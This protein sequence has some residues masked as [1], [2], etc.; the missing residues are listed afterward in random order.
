MSTPHSSLV[1][2]AYLRCEQITK[3]AG[4]NFHWGFRFLP[5]PERQALYALYS[6]A[7]ITDDIVDDEG[8]DRASALKEWESKTRSALAGKPVSDPV[9]LALS[10]AAATFNMPHDEIFLLIEGCRDD[11]TIRRYETFDETLGYCRK[12]AVTVGMLMLAIFRAESDPAAR[13]GMTAI[14]HAFQLTNILR[15]VPEDLRRDRIYLPLAVM[16]D[17]GISE[18]ALAAGEGTREFMAEMV[19]RTETRYREAEILYRRLS[20]A[21][22][23]TMKAMGRIYEAIL[24]EIKSQNYD[25]WSRRPKVSLVKKIRIIISTSLG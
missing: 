18:E 10:H 11:L 3:A 21:P 8:P 6:F 9:L 15:D 23:K 1:A 19:A 7:R 12:V 22:A 5:L 25:V 13:D 16:K 14:G 17:Y 24:D 4:K 2:G 20:P